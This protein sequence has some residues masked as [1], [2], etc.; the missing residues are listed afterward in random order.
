MHNGVGCRMASDGMDDVL[1]DLLAGEGVGVVAAE[2]EDLA[3]AEEFG[4]SGGV[5]MEIIYILH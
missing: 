4:G 3:V 2:D 1:V 5:G